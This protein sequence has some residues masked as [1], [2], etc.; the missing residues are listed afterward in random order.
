MAP[1]PEAPREVD[2]D[3]LPG[4]AAGL[5]SFVRDELIRAAASPYF[6]LVQ[7]VAVAGDD[8]ALE[9]LMGLLDRHLKLRGILWRHGL[10]P[11]N[12]YPAL[13]GKVWEA[14][15]KWDGRDFRAYVARIVR[16]HCLDD[17][18]RKKRAP[19]TIEGAEHSDP[20]APGQTSRI[21]SA[22][23]A[24][25][26]VLAVL[27]ELEASGRIKAIDGVMFTLVSQGR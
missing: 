21:A 19:G 15:P 14:I 4:G 20:R 16:N 17:I 22:R 6:T 23:D 24:M 27:D 2:V 8:Q 18:A 3:A 9:Q 5:A 13:W 1:E 12:E 26:F 10:E 11:D 25:S 7:Q